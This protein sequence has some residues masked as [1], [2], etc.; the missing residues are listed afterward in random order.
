MNRIVI[1]IA[2]ALTLVACVP[3]AQEEAVPVEQEE[4][5]EPVEQ[6]ESV[7]PTE[8]GLVE[9]GLRPAVEE[10]LDELGG[11]DGLRGLDLNAERLIDEGAGNCPSD[12]FEIPGQGVHAMG[13]IG[14]LAVAPYPS[15]STPGDVSPTSEEIVNLSSP[16]FDQRAAILVIDDFNGDV[17]FPDQRIDDAPVTLGSLRERLPEELSARALQQ[18]QELEKLERYGQLSHGSLVFNHTLSLLRVLSSDIKVDFLGDTL[19][20]EFPELG[21]VVFAVDTEKFNTEVIAERTSDAVQSVFDKLGISRFAIN[22][23]FGLVPCSVLE[24]FRAAKEGLESPALTFEKYVEDVL[25]KNGLAGK[26]REQLASLLTTPIEND[27][28]LALSEEGISLPSEEEENL[29]VEFSGEEANPIMITYLAAAGNYKYDWSLAPGYWSEFVSVS[30]ENLSGPAGVKDPEY[31]NT[32]EVLLSGGFFELTFYDPANRI[33]VTYP[34][35][36][37]AGTSFAA[38]V[39]SVYTALD[40]THST[41]RCMPTPLSPLAYFNTDPPVSEPLPTLNEPLDTAVNKCP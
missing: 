38:P 31:S 16:A 28:L 5:T 21:I 6:E 4:A 27:P 24:D 1:G 2:L 23:S 18:E 33:W 34:D 25:L 41:P 3:G 14:G 9:G 15:G 36:S 13:S 17:Y 20:A 39:L 35:I 30:A 10:L 29:D 40:F 22:L 11:R 26:L 7:E 19:F 12:E 37:V 32:G 8:E